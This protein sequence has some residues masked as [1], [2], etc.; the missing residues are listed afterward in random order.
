MRSLLLCL[1]TICSV[2]LF[3]QETEREIFVM[4]EEELTDLAAEQ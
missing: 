2:D 4:R 1:L 3:S